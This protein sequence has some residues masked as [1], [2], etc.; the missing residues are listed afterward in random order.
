M[1]ICDLSTGEAEMAGLGLLAS[2]P[3]LLG[4]F[5]EREGALLQKNK[6]KKVIASEEWQTLEV[7]LWCTCVYIHIHNK[8]INKCYK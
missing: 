6:T 4:K 2:H 1:H 5:K 8:Y 3:G 7:V